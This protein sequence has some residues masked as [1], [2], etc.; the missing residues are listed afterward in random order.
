MSSQKEAPGDNRGHIKSTDG[1][2]DRINPTA[3]VIHINNSYNVISN[4]QRIASFISEARAISY[5]KAVAI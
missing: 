1:R 5:A 2:I 3:N 4:G